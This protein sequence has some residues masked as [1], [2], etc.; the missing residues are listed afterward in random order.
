M[1][2]GAV[3][4]DAKNEG[5]GGYIASLAGKAK[6]K[7]DEKLDEKY[8]VDPFDTLD[9]SVAGWRKKGYKVV[10]RTDTRALLVAK[11]STKAL[12]SGGWGWVLAM[13]LTLFT[14]GLALP[15]VV[16]V[17]VWMRATGRIKKVRFHV[18]LQVGEDG[19][20]HRSAV[21]R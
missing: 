16:G 19:R 13:G 4:E 5:A 21:L 2:W 8:G 20:I 11:W 3:G 7:L 6:E 17:W 9:E 10:E 18:T 12:T 1:E 14:G 15:L